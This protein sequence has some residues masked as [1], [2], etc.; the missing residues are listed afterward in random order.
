MGFKEILMGVII[1]FVGGGLAVCGLFM[2]MLPS[3]L[4]MSFPPF[5]GIRPYSLPIAIV[6]IVF[7]VAILIYGRKMAGLR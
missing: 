7:G 1:A 2:I 3:L 5:A 6:M 4:E